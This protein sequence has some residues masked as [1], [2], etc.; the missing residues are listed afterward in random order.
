MHGETF[1]F[2]IWKAKVL[3]SFSKYHTPLRVAD[4]IDPE[5]RCWKMDDVLA[6]FGADITA[7]NFCIPLSWIPC[8]DR[9]TWRLASNIEIFVKTTYHCAKEVWGCP[10]PPTVDRVGVWKLI[11]DVKLLPKVKHFL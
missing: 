7:M 9:L 3:M 5:M 6:F 2:W 8:D 11:W 4:F 1:G 10:S